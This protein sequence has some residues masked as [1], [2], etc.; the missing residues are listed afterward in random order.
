MQKL[1]DSYNTFNFTYNNSGMF[2]VYASSKEE[3][4]K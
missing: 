1:V 3:G 4:N 2:G